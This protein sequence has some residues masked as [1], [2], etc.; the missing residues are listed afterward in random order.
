VQG[1]VRDFLVFLS[2]LSVLVVKKTE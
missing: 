1:D 2:D